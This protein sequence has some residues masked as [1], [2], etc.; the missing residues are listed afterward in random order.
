MKRIRIPGAVDIVISEDAAE[1][2]S[3]AQN[4]GL[5]RAYADQSIATNGLILRRVLKVLQF[6]GKRFPTVSPKDAEN[7]AAL[8]QAL[9]IRLNALAPHFASGPDELESLAAFVRGQR[10]DD[11]C[12]LLVQQVVGSL[13]NP[14]FKATQ[15]SWDA[16]VVLDKAPRTMN[17]VL[18][19]WWALTGKVDRARLLLAE[20]VGGDL[21]GIHAIGIALHNIVDGVNQMRQLYN[22][23]AQRAALSGE[24]ASKRCLFAPA[25]VLRQPTVPVGSSE[26]DLQTGTLLILKLQSANAGA[27]SED[28]AF[29]S[30][31]WS[32]CPAE[33]WVPAL[34]QGIWSRASDRQTQINS[35]ENAA[36][37]PI[38]HTT[39]PA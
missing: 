38:A 12:G 9:W 13:F 16:A 37:C 22:D 1:I 21:A 33:Q 7:R 8:Q 19:L 5:D 3:L 26:G 18:P 39:P 20:M 34:L 2:Q 4:P 23:P 31:A 25:T 30:Q 6:N 27:P 17:P 32:R 24:A 29:L 35:H 14:D 36:A 28:L 15:A 11:T 10:P